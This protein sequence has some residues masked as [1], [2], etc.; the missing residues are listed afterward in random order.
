MMVLVP[1]AQALRGHY[2]D[3]SGSVT[4]I[5]NGSSFDEPPKERQIGT[6][7]GERR[8]TMIFDSFRFHL[9]V[10]KLRREGEITEMQSASEILDILLYP[11]KEVLESLGQELGKESIFVVACACCLEAFSLACFD[12]R[13]L[14]GG[15]EPVREFW[16]SWVVLIQPGMVWKYKEPVSSVEKEKPEVDRIQKRIKAVWTEVHRAVDDTS[17]RDPA[18]KI[19]RA[20]CLQIDPDETHLDSAKVKILARL[21]NE[22]RMLARVFIRKLKASRDASQ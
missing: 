17:R 10:S 12:N 8:S 22:K 20:A 5:N 16:Q 18:L 14:L 2:G 4:K 15:A 13:R 6:R 11:P 3:R 19:A 1:L 21:T 7:H 9:A